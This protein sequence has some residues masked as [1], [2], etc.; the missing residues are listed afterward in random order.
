MVGR[1]KEA[2]IRV[3]SGLVVLAGEQVNLATIGGCLQ[4]GPALRGLWRCRVHRTPLK[5]VCGVKAIDVF[6]AGIHAPLGNIDEEHFVVTGTDVPR[7]PPLEQ[8]VVISIDAGC[9]FPREGLSDQ[10][11]E[12]TNCVLIK[13]PDESSRDLHVTRAAD[14]CEMRVVR[15]ENPPFGITIEALEDCG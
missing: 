4:D 3:A 9:L 10:V 8:I 2:E 13:P 11:G 5:D 15:G 14:R 6:V 7:L 12:G 1:H